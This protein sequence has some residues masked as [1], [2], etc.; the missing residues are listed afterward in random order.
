[1]ATI[2]QAHNFISDRL[3]EIAD[4]LPKEYKLTIVARHAGELDA[5]IVLTD[6]PELEKA[7]EA[8]RALDDRLPNAKP[9]NVNIARRAEPAP[10]T[11]P[12]EP[13]ID[14]RAAIDAWIRANAARCPVCTAV[15][16]S[17][18][19]SHVNG[20]PAVTREAV[21]PIAEQ[22]GGE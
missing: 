14:N 3:A 1:M 4:F 15:I 20:C 13:Q 9:G 19:T 10:M 17:Y 12:V 11:R 5:D 6:E 21:P 22:K 16:W 18:N 8:I 7:I 2:R